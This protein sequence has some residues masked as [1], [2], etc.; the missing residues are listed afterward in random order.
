M[1]SAV[2]STSSSGTPAEWL[3]LQYAIFHSSSARN[4]RTCTCIS[5]HRATERTG[6]GPIIK[7]N[8]V[9]QTIHILCCGSLLS[10][11]TDFVL[12]MRKSVFGSFYAALETSV[13]T[14]TNTKVIAMV[15]PHFNL[16]LLVAMDQLSSSVRDFYVTKLLFA[17]PKTNMGTEQGTSGGIRP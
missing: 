8:R 15:T 11:F 4:L 3:P 1:Q 6:N 2:F 17:N 7:P 9:I 16:T 14:L 5:C 10:T 13:L 12:V